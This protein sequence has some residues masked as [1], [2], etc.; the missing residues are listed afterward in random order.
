MSGVSLSSNSSD[1]ASRCSFVSHWIEDTSRRIPAVPS[2]KLNAGARLDPQ[3]LTSAYSAA[4][5][6]EIEPI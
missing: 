1:Q 3:N 5:D 6:F 2:H 4:G